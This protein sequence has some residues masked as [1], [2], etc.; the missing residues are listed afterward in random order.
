[1]EL[2]KNIT[3]IGEPDRFCKI[4]VEDYVVSYLKQLN[5]AARNKDIAV[6]VY[7]TRKVEG[8]VSYLFLYGACR[9]DF[10]QRETKHLSQAQ[11]QEIER[12]RQRYFFEYEFQGYRLLNG[13]MIEGFHICENGICRYIAGYAQF[14]EKNDSMLNF[15]LETRSGEVQPEVVDQE[16]YEVVKRRQEERKVQVE[17]SRQIPSHR[18]A[19]SNES[20]TADGLSRIERQE[21]SR[22]WK[23]PEKNIQTSLRRMKMA[24]VAVF[25]LLCMAGLAS[26]NGGQG[27]KD[28]QVWAKQTLAGVTEQKLPDDSQAVEVMGTSAA[29]DT[30]VAE[31]RL[32]DAVRQENEQSTQES[33]VQAEPSQSETLQ[34]DT[35]NPSVGT[36][37]N[38]QPEPSEAG[39]VK[40]SEEVEN[41]AEAGASAMVS[42][43]IKQGDTLTNICVRNYGSDA[44]LQ[45]IC[46]INEISDPDDI[47]VGQ[48]I[49]LP[50]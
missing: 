48:K 19:S 30:L 45:E 37:S 20:E 9:L 6:A 1:M 18:V 29:S 42:Y 14:Y 4:Y 33:S 11:Q 36:D 28:L 15:M 32:T 50:Q 2:P 26:M 27:I 47:K 21:L 43:V 40:P 38:E 8:E 17:E 31:D 49:L 16:K 35:M 3:Q 23:K 41:S 39:E 34:S 10:L 25:A 22:A 44:R 7:G 12:N 24:A 5:Q 13:D 46:N